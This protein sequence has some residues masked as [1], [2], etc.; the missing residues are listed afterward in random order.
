MENTSN[1]KIAQALELLNEAAREKKDEVKSLLT[2]KYAHLKEAIA[3]GT[4]QGRQVIEKAQQFAKETTIAADKH[5]REN[6]WAYIGGAAA[7]SVVLG[8]LMGSRRK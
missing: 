2:D 8:Y 4:E 1:V 6:P 5:V 7:V 3:G